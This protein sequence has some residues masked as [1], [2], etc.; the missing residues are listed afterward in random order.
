MLLGGDEFGRTQ[1]GNNNAYCHDDE[2]SWIDWTTAD[3]DPGKSLIEF[4]AR[5]IKA[6]KDRP[7]LHA[8]HFYT[9][10][11]EILPGLYD[12]SWFDESGTF[13][14]QEK[15]DFGEGRLL[16]L[17]RV[18]RAEAKRNIAGEVSAS[19]LLVNASSEDREFVL[20]EPLL[21]WIVLIDGAETADG[22]T[23]RKPKDNRITVASHCALLLVADHVEL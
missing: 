7:T 4:T 8:A 13:M 9:G 6:R 20:P 10:D 22:P 15:W 1:H 16:A 19:L 23:V 18:A 3:S 14:D 12:T 11:M 21:D 17:R 5:C 2:L